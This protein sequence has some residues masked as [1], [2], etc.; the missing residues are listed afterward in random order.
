M[1]TVISQNTKERKEETRELFEQ[2]RPYLDEGYS[3]NS[4]IRQV[5][6]NAHGNYS[7]LGWYRDVVQYGESQGYPR[8]E[9]MRNTHNGM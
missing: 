8:R 4:A 9:H 7:G 5:K 6:K 1:I 2:I 3:Y